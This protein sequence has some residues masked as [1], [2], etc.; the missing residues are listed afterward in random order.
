MNEINEKVSSVE[1]ANFK[2][3]WEDYYKIWIVNIVLT[4]CTFGIYSAWAKVRRLKFF[5]GA[6]EF[7][8]A[9]FDFH[10]DPIAILKGRVLMTIL[11]FLYLFTPKIHFIFSFIGIAAIVLGL[12]FLLVKSF[13]FRLKYTSYRNIRF[14]F[15]GDLKGAYDIL[16]KYFSFPIIMFVLSIVLSQVLGIAEV[17]KDPNFKASPKV[18]IAIIPNILMTIYFILFFSKIFHAVVDYIFNN[19]FYGNQNV[20]LNSTPRDVTKD[21]YAP[22]IKLFLLATI[23]IFVGAFLGAY[24]G[25]PLIV[26]FFLGAYSIYTIAGLYL[27]YSMVKF[28][29]SKSTISSFEN[30]FNLDFKDYVKVTFINF[31]IIFLSFGL[32]YPIASVKFQKMMI[33]AKGTSFEEFDNVT[34]DQ[35]DEKS[36]ASEEVL[37][38]LDIGFEFG[39]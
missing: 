9:R 5:L 1:Y 3:K 2:G 29:W 31:L 6:T 13:Q 27:S 11:V 26:I 8:G 24:L 36:A 14:S 23:I 16:K 34:S 30:D 7:K 28:P 17:A 35:T 20:S 15:R 4:I 18:F 37:D 19:I 10:G 25:G 22:W 33:E 39:I 21:I 12:P 32:A 38:S